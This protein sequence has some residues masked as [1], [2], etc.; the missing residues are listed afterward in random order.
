M[1]D[2]LPEELT[3]YPTTPFGRWVLAVLKKHGS[4][5]RSQRQRTK[6]AHTTVMNWLQDTQPSMQGV[7]AFARGFDEDVDE[8]LRLAGYA[9]LEEDL[10]SRIAARAAADPEGTAQLIAA[11]VRGEVSGRAASELL[12]R[13]LADKEAA[14]ESRE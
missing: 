9:S 6:L 1:Q 13:L 7:T 11:G 12:E 14:R 2:D 4:S 8:A 3:T 10:S 5:L